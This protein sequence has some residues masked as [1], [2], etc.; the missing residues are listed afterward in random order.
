MLEEMFVIISKGT[1][2]LNLKFITVVHLAFGSLGAIL[3]VL[4]VW[5]RDTI[6][7]LGKDER[8]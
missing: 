5:P 8:T 2:V 6:A 7:L 1:A 4:S 3:I